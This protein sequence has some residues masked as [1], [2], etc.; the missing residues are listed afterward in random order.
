SDPDGN[1]LTCSWAQ[2]KVYRSFQGDVTISAPSAAETS[3]TIPSDAKAGDVIHMIL[4]V[5]DNGTP[6]LASYLRTVITVE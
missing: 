3:V 5:E 6:K 4:T 1:A 2:W